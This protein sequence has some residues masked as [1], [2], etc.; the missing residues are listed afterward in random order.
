[1]M[2][3]PRSRVSA[4]TAIS[5]LRPSPLT[6]IRRHQLFSVVVVRHATYHYDVIAKLCL[7]LADL[8]VIRRARFQG[9]SNIFKLGVQAALGFPPECAP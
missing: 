8:G 1:M 5:V 3:L 2:V 9:E 7:G 6:A 4:L